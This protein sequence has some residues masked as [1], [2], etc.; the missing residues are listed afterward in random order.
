MDSSLHE[1]WLAAAGSPFLPTVGKGSQFLVGFVLLLLGIIATGVFALNRSLVNVFAVGIPASLA[2]AY[3]VVYMFCAVGVYVSDSQ[4]GHY[5][6]TDKH[7]ILRAVATSTRPLYQLLRCINFSPKVHV[8]IT[9]EGIRFAADHAKVMQGV[10]FLNKSLFSSY[11]VNLPPAE[12]GEPPELPNFQIPLSSFLEILQIFG[13]VDVAARAQKAEQDPYR[14]NLRNYRPDAFSNQTLGI[15]GTCTLV[16]GQEGDPFKVMIEESGVQTTAGL[17]TYVPEITDDIPLDRD[18]IWFKIIM[19]SRSLLDSL[20]EISPTAPMKL[21]ITTSKTSPYLSF[22]GKGDLGSSDVDFARGRELLETF[23][24]RDKWTQ[25]YKFDF[26]KNSTE[27]MRIANKVSL[28]GDG[29]GV[30]S[31]QFLVDIEGGKRSFL[32]FR[33]V[34]FAANDD[35]EE[36]EEED[37]VDVGSG[38]EL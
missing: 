11:S 8:Q 28:R 1:V 14:S 20:A 34:P 22:T 2:L 29:Q 36:Y 5:V 17:A 10:A 37:N 21:S 30:L 16:Y 19:Q 32:D 13:A 6:M 33:F 4:E 25:S 12:D 18:D 23:S 27:A 15:S 24:I 7:P 35:E 3:G 26:I 9:E 38:P 31:L